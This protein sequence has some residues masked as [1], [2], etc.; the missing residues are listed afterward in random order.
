MT[1]VE[2]SL[3]ETFVGQPSNADALPFA[4]G[5]QSWT[6][7]VAG[8]AEPCLVINRDAT[9]LAVSAT[10]CELLGLG[11]PGAAVGRS[12]MDGALCL[13]DFTAGRGQLPDAE[14]EKIPPLLA[15]SSQRL[16]RGLMRVQL[17]GPDGT[18][19]TVDAIATP[20]LDDGRVAASLTFFSAV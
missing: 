14:A 19:V 9:I 3:S 16:A 12:L 10:C 11:R 4:A 18:D 17:D 8:A 15:L 20:L 1:H 2:F 13:I 7:T 6:A 5:L